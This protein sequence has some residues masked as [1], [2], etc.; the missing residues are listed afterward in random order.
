VTP[1]DIL[2][3]NHRGNPTYQS[4]MPGMRRIQILRVSVD[5]DFFLVGGKRPGGSSGWKWKFMTLIVGVSTFGV[6][7]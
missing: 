1:Q 2:T 7:R 5:N 3:G 4:A 6:Y